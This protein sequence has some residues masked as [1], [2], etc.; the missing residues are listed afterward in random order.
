[1]ASFMCTPVSRSAGAPVARFVEREVRSYLECGV[2][3]HTRK[4]GLLPT[5]PL[6]C[7]QPRPTR[8]VF[9]QGAWILSILRRAK[10]GT[11]KLRFLP[12]FHLVDRVLP[13]MP[14][15]QWVLTLPYP[16]RYRCAW[17]AR[18]TS[19]VLRCFLRAVFA[20]YRRRA[21]RDHGVR[22]GA[23]GSVTFTQRF[24]SGIG[25]ILTRTGRR[26]R[27]KVRAAPAPSSLTRI[28][29]T[30]SSIYDMHGV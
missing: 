21:K 27:W 14:V 11:R 10:N 5:S 12:T 1:M 28:S 25:S 4:L 24:G 26:R 8:R 22:G 20:D 19:E 2:L 15:R 17:N 9:L 6:R 18:L 16:L 3:A 29:C 7:L 30:M 13:D 23:C